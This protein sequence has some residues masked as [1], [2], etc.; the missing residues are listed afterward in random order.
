MVEVV[1]AFTILMITMLPLT[2]LYGSSI[3]QAGQ[4]TNQQTALSIAEQW[5]ETLSNVTPPVDSNGEVFVGTQS[6]PVGA[7]AATTTIPTAITGQAASG[8]T[9]LTVSST[10]GFSASGSLTVVTT[11]GQQT[12][13]YTSVT[14]TSPYKFSGVTGWR[15]TTVSTLAS[16][17]VAQATTTQSAGGVT[18][19]LLAEYDW[20]TLQGTGNGGQPN[21]CLAGTPQLLKLT[22]S[23]SWGPTTDTNNV[24]DSIVL[25]YP[26]SG[27]Q[28]LG[29][30]ALQVNGDQTALDTQANPWS[31]RVTAP[32][33]T[34]TQTSGTPAQSTLTIYPDSNGCAFAQVEPGTYTVSLANA[35]SGI[36]AGHSS[37]TTYGSPPFVE[38]ATGTISNHELTQPQ[39]VSN[40]TTVV[41]GA[42]SRLTASFDQG[43]IINVNYPSSTS[44]E[45]GVFCPGLGVL[46]CIATGETGTGTGVAG[47]AVL[48]V[49]NQGT[50]QWAPASLPSGVTRL[51]SVACAGASTRCIGVGYGSSGAVIV[52][53]LTTAAGFGNDTFPTGLASLSQVICPS[54]TTCVAV[55][56]TTTGAAAVLTGTIGVGSDTWQTDAI[57]AAPT[58]ATIAGL[59]NLVCPS[60]SGGCIASATST[61]PS[62]GTPVIVSGGYGL[63][64]TESSPN[65]TGVTLTGITNVACPSTATATT[66]VLTGTTASGPKVV[67][68]TASAGLGVAAPSWTWA[69][70][71]F[72]TGTTPTAIS[73]LVCPTSSKCLVSGTT[74]TAAFVV[75]GATT[76]ATGVALAADTL[77]TGSATATQL[78]CPNANYC[79]VIGTTSAPAPAIA[80]AS[81]GATNSPDTWSAVTIPSPPV[82]GQTISQLTGV[83]C[84]TNPACA[85]TAIGTNTGGQPMAFLLTGTGSVP[86]W[87]ASALPTGNP[88]FYLGDVDC[89]QPGTSICSAVGAGGTG[90]V[91]LV[92]SGG[93]TGAWSD[94]TPTSLTGLST[95]GIPTEIN[96]ANLQP[97][98]YQTFITAG[99][100]SLTTPFPA[101]YPFTSGYNVYAGDCPAEQQSG[102]N[103]AVATTIPGGTSTSTVPLGLLSVE[104]FHSSGNSI[105]LPYAATLSLTSTASSPCGT[106]TYTLQAA[107][108]ADGLSRTEVPY[109]TYTLTITTAGGTTTVNSVTVGGSS[110]SVASTAYPLPAPVVEKVS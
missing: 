32:P 67:M 25:N 33:V 103:V 59:S 100:S 74:S 38:N 27:I 81:V 96:N 91:E 58:S 4:S 105:G 24:Q 75:Y 7:G 3:I 82:S 31:E 14:T 76:P 47:T 86:T 30:I 92:S 54:S 26:P 11:A 62:A 22:V 55:G 97:N 44:T 89:V 65:P 53:S 41:I 49:Y 56:A 35:T 23:V 72:P 79:V 37:D 5:V 102:L 10:S 29:F 95:T 110:V 43:S 99:W 15:T 106:D 42:V 63:G 77:P 94:Q 108:A 6:A 101:L 40:T 52:S 93:P 68:G 21:L 45:D 13:H 2:Y 48:T 12:V 1:V 50:A 39:S 34:I 20:T 36:L 109:G 9:T 88:A 57:T 18:Y 107:S 19:A 71:T 70:D 16:A 61:S 28:T 85:I 73:G 84:W 8:L 104:V 66:C 46:T 69:A 17:S 83:T 78:A 90:A 87:G 98:P 80:W 51:T 60:G 64:W